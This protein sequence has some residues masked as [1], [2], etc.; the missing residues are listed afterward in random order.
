MSL[1]EKVE[2]LVAEEADGLLK[3]VKHI[4]AAVEQKGAGAAPAVDDV[5]LAGLKSDF[6]AKAETFL[7]DR[8]VQ[9]DSKLAELESEVA[10]ALAKLHSQPAAAAA[11]A[12]ASGGGETV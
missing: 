7:A 5:L 10:A 1:V 6:D 4:A 8:K 9:V 3:A 11:P 12:A 2:Q